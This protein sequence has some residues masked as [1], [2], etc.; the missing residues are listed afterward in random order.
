MDTNKLVRTYVKIRD[1]RAE[2]KAKYE[3]DDARLKGQLDKIESV[4]LKMTDDL[5]INSLK[6]EA[7]TATR[8]QRT[9]YWAADWDAFKAFISQYDEGLDLVERRIHQGNFK[10]FME[11]HPDVV[12]PVNADS[13]FAITVRRGK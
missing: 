2:L 4:L 8:T 3:D 7:G 5:G 12:P 9:R 1:A 10:D 13:K 11:R 6:T